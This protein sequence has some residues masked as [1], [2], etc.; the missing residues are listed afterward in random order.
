MTSSNIDK[1]NMPESEKSK[2]IL[3]RKE[4]HLK[5]PI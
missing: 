2:D 3:R 5:I 4:E 1:K